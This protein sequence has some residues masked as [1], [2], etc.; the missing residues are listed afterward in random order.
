MNPL[1]PPNAADLATDEP[2]NALCVQ[3]SDGFSAFV[4]HILHL[5]KVS[6]SVVLLA[7][8]YVHRMSRIYP[9][10]T[11]GSEKLTFVIALMLGNKFLDE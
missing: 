2:F 10:P 5:T 6:H 8:L 3:V 9:Y 11:Q 7:L 4:S 1:I